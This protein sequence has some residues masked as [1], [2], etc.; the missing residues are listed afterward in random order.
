MP[1]STRSTLDPGLRL[2]RAGLD[3]REQRGVIALVL[4]GVGLCEPGDLLVEA[5]AG[6]KVGG[7]LDL[8]AR[9][10]VCAGERPATR[11]RVDLEVLGLHRLDIRRPLRVPQLTHVEVALPPVDADRAD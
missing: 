4:V 6:A 3:G 9:A 8:I 10:R 2:D 7:D 11:L 1:R 5:V